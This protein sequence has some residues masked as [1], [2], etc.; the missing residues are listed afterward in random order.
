MA[1]SFSKIYD[2]AVFKI[3]DFK[4]LQGMSAEALALTQSVLRRYLMSSITDFQHAC[5]FNLTDYNEA[6]EYF[7]DDLDDEAIEI[8]ALG[9]AFHWLD[10]QTLNSEL[11]RNIIH[12]K[13]Y[14][15]YS[16]GN[17]LKEVRTLRSLYKQEYDGK[18]N[19]YSFRY[20][21]VDT[22]KT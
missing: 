17:L 8:L 13:D 6:D 1:T 12:P 5:R 9:I 22:L 19:T 4:Y 3:T 11:L 16:P 21:N 10:A 15:S 14:E 7:N 18:I 20:G 2:R